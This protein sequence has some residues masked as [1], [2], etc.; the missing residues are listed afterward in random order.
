MTGS[1]AKYVMNCFH[2]IYLVENILEIL[3]DETL[4][5]TLS[6]LVPFNL[7]DVSIRVTFLSEPKVDDCRDY[8]LTS[9]VQ[10]V[11]SL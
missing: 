3:L 7:L 8:T 9:T 1:L 5:L 6:M 4:S 2:V 10:H 11:V